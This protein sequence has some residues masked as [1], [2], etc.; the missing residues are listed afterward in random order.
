M[1]VLAKE[2]IIVFLVLL[3]SRAT[4]DLKLFP[5][6]RMQEIELQH[7]LVPTCP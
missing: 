6:A 3:E 2:I 1:N 7:S 4:V 5:F